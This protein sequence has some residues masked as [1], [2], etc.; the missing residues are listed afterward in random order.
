MS[1][2]AAFQEKFEQPASAVSHAQAICMISCHV[3]QGG[4]G[5][6]ARPAVYPMAQRS[7]PEY[8]AAF[9][10]VTRSSGRTS[11]QHAVF[12]FCLVLASAVARS[13]SLNTGP[14]TRTSGCSQV[15]W[16]KTIMDG[17]SCR[18]VS[19]KS[20]AEGHLIR[21]RLDF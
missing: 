17:S 10:H 18:D 1:S 12:D 16:M 6:A 21:D 13:L 15:S 4:Q 19:M 14:G 5:S 2:S 20:R 11:S 7:T 3:D 8:A 9:L